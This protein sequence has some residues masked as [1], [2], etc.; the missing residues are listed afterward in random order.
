MA[1][2]IEEM[3]TIN[4]QIDELQRKLDQVNNFQPKTDVGV[5]AKKTAFTELEKK[6]EDL[7]MHRS[8]LSGRLEIETVAYLAGEDTD[9][10]EPTPNETLRRAAS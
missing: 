10:Y 7:R 8:E 5:D 9:F 3:A 4:G 2:T 6:I 1:A